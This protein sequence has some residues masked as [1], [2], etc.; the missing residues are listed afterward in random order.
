MSWNLSK[1]VGVFA[2]LAALAVSATN[3]LGW[4][5]PI[6][7]F[8][9]GHT[10]HMWART[11]NYPNSLDTPVTRYYMPR[12]PG[13]CG[14]DGPVNGMGCQGGVPMGGGGQYGSVPYSVNAAAGFEPVS[15]ERLGRVPNELNLGGGIALPT[16][17]PPPARK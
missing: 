7:C 8:I 6:G 1:A 14:S 16:A 12:Q 4:C 2:F 11:W 13:Y 10:Y 5:G 3:C 17:G 15:F 9:D